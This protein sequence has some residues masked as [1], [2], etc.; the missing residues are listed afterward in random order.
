MSAT[1]LPIPAILSV[2]TQ[3]GVTSVPAR[4]ATFCK[5]TDGAA[6]VR[7]LG[8]VYSP[9]TG[10]H[11]CDVSGDKLEDLLPWA[12]CPCRKWVPGDGG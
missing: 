11:A 1:R 8:F 2:K 12:Q 4:K 7:D 9:A 5:R 10:E 3:R 6:K